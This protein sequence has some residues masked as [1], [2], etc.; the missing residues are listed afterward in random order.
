MNNM[1]SAV[2]Y[3]AAEGE[4][5]DGGGEKGTPPSKPS[6]KKSKSDPKKQ[7]TKK[8]RDAAKGGDVPALKALLEAGASVNGSNK[9]GQTALMKA[10]YQGHEEALATLLDARAKVSKL[11]KKG[12]SALMWAAEA[13]S[14]QCAVALIEKGAQL[15]ELLDG[16]GVHALGIAFNHSKYGCGLA[17]LKASGKMANWAE[18]EEGEEAEVGGSPFGGVA[19]LLADLPAS[20]EAAEA[21]SLLALALRGDARG[22]DKATMVPTPL[23][24]S[25]LRKLVHFRSPTFGFT[26]II[27]AAFVGS[28]S[29]TQ[30]LVE[31]KASFLSDQ[32]RDGNTA[33]H[34]AC[35]QG[36]V[37]A[38]C[39]RGVQWACVALFLSS[40]S[41]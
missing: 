20:P 27:G 10:A 15:V 34:W 23:P 36:H 30:R 1:P 3:G 13:G 38:S 19:T 14:T 32:D 39:P 31:A 7:A 11:D 12:R 24:L 6:S 4:G 28:V 16:E 40:H 8:L 26:P 2:G 33:L 5:G 25:Q 35:I 17:M 37:Q 9:Q 29:V 18:L 41:L 22:F 21:H